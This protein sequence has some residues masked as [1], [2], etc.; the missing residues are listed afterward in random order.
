MISALQNHPLGQER[1]KERKKM[2]HIVIIPNPKRDEGL[3][4]T[5]RLSK[6]LITLGAVVYVDEKYENDFPSS[7]QRY[8]N[9]PS[10]ADL[11]IVVGGDGSILDASSVALKYDLPLVGV[12]LGKVGYLS[13]IELDELDVLNRLFSGQYTVNEKM[14]LTVSKVCA[15]E[16]K[17]CERLAVNDVIISHDSFLGIADFTLENSVGDSL[18]YRAD[19]LILSTPAGSTAY[20][21]SAGGPIVS[22]DIDSI[23]A[24]PICPHS[25]FKR[26]IIFKS[27]ESIKIKNNSYTPLK[28]SV[29]GR[30]FSSLLYDEACIIKKANKRLKVLTF[31]ENNMFSTLF[32]KMRILEDIQ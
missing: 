20:S 25:F 21:L 4:V 14:L 9:F 18:K 23:T 27:E 22:H 12:N 32:K 17:A 19:G 29:D 24:T 11:I 8:G 31:C 6:M 15:G 10:C 13:E 26:Y 28:L 30:Y 2:K 5:K 7:V 1:E 16:E 3:S